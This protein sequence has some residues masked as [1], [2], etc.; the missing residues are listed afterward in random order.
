MAETSEIQPDKIQHIWCSV[1]INKKMEDVFTGFILNQAQ[2]NLGVTEY[3]VYISTL[4]AYVCLTNKLINL[5][6]VLIIT[7][8]L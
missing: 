8:L 2:N 6:T 7:L 1:S 5:S 4:R 3:I